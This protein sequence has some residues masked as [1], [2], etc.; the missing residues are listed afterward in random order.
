MSFEEML[1]LT[2]FF[3]FSSD[4]PVAARFHACLPSRSAAWCALPPGCL[5]ILPPARTGRCL[6]SPADFIFKCLRVTHVR[7][8]TGERSSALGRRHG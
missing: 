2:A 7:A 3:Y 4:N 8:A 6:A 1:D 5:P